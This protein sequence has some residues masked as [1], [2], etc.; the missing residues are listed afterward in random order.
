VLRACAERG[1][2]QS[3]KLKGL[4]RRGGKRGQIKDLVQRAT[5]CNDAPAE[6]YLESMCCRS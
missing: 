6:S 3:S 4:L 1:R 5:A 2:A